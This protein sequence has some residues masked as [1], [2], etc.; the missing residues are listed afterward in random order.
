MK[1]LSRCSLPQVFSKFQ[2]LFPPPDDPADMVGGGTASL[3]SLDRSRGP[4]QGLHD[5]FRDKFAGPAGGGL[6]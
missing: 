2:Q 3:P 5:C 6:A 4:D 1:P